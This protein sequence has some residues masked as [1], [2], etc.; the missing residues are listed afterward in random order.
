MFW[1][2]PLV[3]VVIMYIIIYIVLKTSDNRQESSKLVK[4]GALIVGTGVLAYVP[5]A[6]FN[7]FNIRYNYYLAQVHE[8]HNRLSILHQNHSPYNCTEPVCN[9]SRAIFRLVR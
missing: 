6:T 2:A 3:S 7:A 1:L 4:I 5:E 8:P 9:S